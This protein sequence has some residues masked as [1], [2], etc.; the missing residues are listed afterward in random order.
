MIPLKLKLKKV[1]AIRDMEGCYFKKSDDYRLSSP[2]CYYKIVSV[3]EINN[4][5][6]V[7]WNE[8]ITSENRYYDQTIGLET[9]EHHFIKGNWILVKL[10]DVPERFIIND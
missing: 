1:R 2:L 3:N 7:R 4:S 9:V 10:E 8:V 5:V 6:Y